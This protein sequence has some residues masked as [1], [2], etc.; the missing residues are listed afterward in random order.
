MPAPAPAPAAPEAPAPEVIEETFEI[1]GEAAAP[2]E[3]RDNLLGTATYDLPV[4][5]NHWVQMEL[6]FLVNQRR[7]TIGR[8]ME[9]GDRYQAWVQEVFAGYGIPRDLHHLAMVE[10]GYT[11]TARSHAGALGMWQFM[12]ATGRGMGLRIDELVDERMDPVRS[13]HAAARHL[14]DLHRNFG[15][16]WA[17]AAAAYNAG[18]GRISRGLGRLGAT[19]FWD[20]AVR[21]DLAQETRHYV[22]RLF[23]VTIIARDPARFGYPDLRGTA[24]PFAYD[25]VRVDVPTPLAELARIANLPVS[26]LTELNPHLR[27]GM[28]PADYWVWTPDG[29]GPAVQVVFDASEL[30]REGG[31]GHYT[32]R[33]GESVAELAEAT[34]LPM[35]RIRDLNL[36]RRLERLGRGDRVRLPAPAI[37]L[38]EARSTRVAAREPERASTRPRAARPSR[39]SETEKPDEADSTSDAGT[40]AR[41]ASR[42]EESRS[43]G[44]R[45]GRRAEASRSSGSGEGRRPGTRT[46]TRS[47]RSHTVESGETLWGIARRFDVTVAQLRD[48][49]SL[50]A[51]EAIQPGQ[52]LRIPREPA[53]DREPEA[54]PRRSASRERRAERREEEAR[55]HT[56]RSGDTLWS[57]ARRYETSVDALRSA[58]GLS[59][60]SSIRPGQELRIPAR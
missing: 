44:S 13:T 8:W 32:L 16:D 5:A 9:R 56:V 47:A 38:L 60:G 7:S 41:S 48:A 55:R 57:I 15:G 21:G 3:V 33:R 24:R 20:L 19:D 34:G 37:R 26:E 35:E 54:A 11:P 10:S 52:S 42:S 6:D 29:T 22:P 40:E 27:Q 18:A 50:S 28:A 1:A 14:R 36:S 59:E 12:P 46:A 25:S 4:V 51:E 30:R 43:S 2:V 49:N 23:A 45:D 31:Y 17:L 53:A 39:R 58:N